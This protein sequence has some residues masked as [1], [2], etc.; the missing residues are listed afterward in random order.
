M[1]T[2]GKGKGEGGRARERE[3][4]RETAENEFLTGLP[5]TCCK[6]GDDVEKKKKKKKSRQKRETVTPSSKKEKEYEDEKKSASTRAPEERT[7]R[8]VNQLVIKISEGFA[9]N[10]TVTF[11]R[12]RFFDELSQERA[13]LG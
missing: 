10:G 9:L 12:P 2:H 5:F 8:D 7:Y 4:E 11:I 13:P 6:E 1:L 3:R